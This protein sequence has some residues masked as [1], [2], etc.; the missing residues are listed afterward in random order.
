MNEFSSI[1]CTICKDISAKE[2][3]DHPKPMI[4]EEGRFVCGSCW[5]ECELV[6][7]MQQLTSKQSNKSVIA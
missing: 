7:E 6:V 3:C 5:Q 2:G 1:E 4:N